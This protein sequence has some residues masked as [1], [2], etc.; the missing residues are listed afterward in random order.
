MAL[1]ERVNCPPRQM[2]GA[3]CSVGILLRDLP[4]GESEALQT[5][6]DDCE[7]WTARAIWLAVS[8]EGHF[9]GHQSIG[10]HRRKSCKCYVA[11]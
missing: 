9:I 6:L 2:H 8:D 3:D 4:P 1:A 11:R 10:R 7:T 5:M